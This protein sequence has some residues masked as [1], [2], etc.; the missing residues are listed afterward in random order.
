M[1]Y[2]YFIL[3]IKLRFFE[4]RSLDCGFAIH[5]FLWAQENQKFLKSNFLI[6]VFSN[7]NDRQIQCQLLLVY[8][9]F[10]GWSIALI[11]CRRSLHQL[12]LWLH[13]DYKVHDT[14][15]TSPNNDNFLLRNDEKDA[16]SKIPWRVNSSSFT[17]H[18][19]DLFHIGLKIKPDIFQL[20]HNL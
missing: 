10:R 4:E 1:L 15:Q 2:S 12:I 14:I 18:K 5:R 16:I 11:V 17:T 13:V 8:S 19:I 3:L 7:E 9:I 20:Y 6:F